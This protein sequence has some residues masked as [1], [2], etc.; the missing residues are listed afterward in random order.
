MW[1]KWTA[2]PCERK[3]HTHTRA[4]P[5]LTLRGN[6]QKVPTVFY[7][8]MIFNQRRCLIASQLSDKLFRHA[9]LKRK[10]KN[11]LNFVNLGVK[12]SAMTAD[13]SLP[14]HPSLFNWLLACTWSSALQDLNNQSHISHIIGSILFIQPAACY[15]W[16][17]MSTSTQSEVSKRAMTVATLIGS[18]SNTLCYSSSEGAIKG[19]NSFQQIRISGFLR[20]SK[21]FR[22]CVS[23]C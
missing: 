2:G 9:V 14:T 12:F 10:Q 1:Y 11:K 8:V 15:C 18:R 5:S 4:W 17:K 19:E 7:C 21:S 16:R 6:W 22:Q 23:N 13:P 3:S 20:V